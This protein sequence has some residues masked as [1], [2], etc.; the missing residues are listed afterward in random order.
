MEE[1]ASG[2][3]FPEGPIALSDGSVLVCE[4]EAG[5]LSRVSPDGTNEVVA[6]TGG[7]PN[8]AAIGPDGAVY[9]CNN[10][11]VFV[12]EERMGL[13]VPGGP[14][15]DGWTGGSIQRV[16]LESGVVDVLYTESQSVD[17]GGTTSTVPLRAPNDLVFDAHGGFWFTDHGARLQRSSDRTGIHYAKADGSSC[18][19]VIHPLDAPN[20][21]GLSPGGGTL[22]TAETHTGR[23]WQ[24]EV[25]GPGEVAVTNPVG[26][27]GGTLLAGLPGMQLL[28]SLAVDAAGWVCVGTLVNGGITAIE[29]D[30]SPIEHTVLPDPLVTN[31]CFGGPGHRTAYVTLS[32]TGKLLAMDWPRPGLPLAYSA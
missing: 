6:E 28:D 16:D 3:R 13:T 2:L 15:P 12:W 27:G 9:V 22:Y 19:E 7:G 18:R 14:P 23:V 26:P 8:G 29:P 24:W 25:T 30:G 21:I 5:R 20:G 17:E 10:G 1:L 32:G 31:I 4:I 11:G